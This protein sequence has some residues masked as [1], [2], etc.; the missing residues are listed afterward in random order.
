[1]ISEKRGK[2][3]KGL[4]GLFEVRIFDVNIFA[5]A[6]FYYIRCVVCK[7]LCTVANDFAKVIESFLFVK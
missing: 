2:V 6:L 5:F 1:M 7:F 4:G 3:I